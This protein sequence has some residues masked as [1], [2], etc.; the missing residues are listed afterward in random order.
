M[1]SDDVFTAAYRAIAEEVPEETTLTVVV[2]TANGKPLGDEAAAA[3]EAVLAEQLATR[4]SQLLA[5]AHNEYGAGPAFLENFRESRLEAQE[6]VMSV[7]PK[8]ESLWLADAVAVTGTKAEIEELAGHEDVAAVDVNRRFRLP[9]ILRTPLED[10]PDLVDGSTWGVAKIGAVDTWSGFGRGDGVLVGVLDTGVD[11]THPALVNK[12]VAFEEFDALGVPMG[13]PPHDSD[14]HG[15]HVC[16]TIAGRTFR[17]TNIGVAPDAK[18][19]VALVLPGGGGTFAQIV[20]GMQWTLGQGVHVMNLSLGGSAYSTAWNLPVLIATLSGTLV[21]ASIGNAGHGTSG[22]P[23]NDVFALG[24]GATDA[25]DI[26]AGFSGGQTLTVPHDVFGTIR[27]MKPDISAPGVSVLSCVP[28]TGQIP[29]GHDMIALSGT[30]MAA[31]HAS[32]AAALLM[33][34]EPGLLGNP[35]SVREILLGAGR[36]DYGEAGRDQR[37]GFGRIDAMSATGAAVSQFS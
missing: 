33:S 35:F 21:V 15:T 34:A 14:I 17:G 37:F 8:A 9:R 23:G 11:D 10:T 31:P 4:P 28:A 27:Y 3:H 25:H 19:A 18:L 1:A 24:V 32:G 12:V 16:G 29:A 5:L 13:T 7:A 30:S 6:R 2:R 26:V 36:E 22:G 20:G